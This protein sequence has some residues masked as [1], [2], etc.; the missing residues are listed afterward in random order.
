MFL[1]DYLSLG[2]CI[3]KMIVL[4]DQ[5]NNLIIFFK[6]D[7]VSKDRNISLF[8]CLL[9]AHVIINARTYL[10]TNIHFLMMLFVAHYY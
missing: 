1:L 10:L 5:S 4:L 2:M 7:I 6:F 3:V 8:V 9:I